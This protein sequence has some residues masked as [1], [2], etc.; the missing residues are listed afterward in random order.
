VPEGGRYRL[1]PVTL[2]D[3]GRIA[4]DAAEASGDLDLDAAGPDITTFRGYVE[5]LGRACGVKRAIFGAPR[6]L[7]LVGIRLIEPL[8]GDCV[9]TGEELAG[10]EQELL[11][12]RK[13][14]LGAEPVDRW[15]LAHGGELGRCYVNDLDRHFGEGKK[16]PVLRP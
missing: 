8:L 6:W 2:D 11:V 7:A 15:L 13:P 5:L 16:E 1:Q 4:A 3:T 9:L 14:P 12:S 10:L